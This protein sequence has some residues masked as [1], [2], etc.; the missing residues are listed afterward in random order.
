MRLKLSLQYRADGH[1]GIVLHPRCLRRRSEQMHLRSLLDRVGDSAVF[2]SLRDL[3]LGK[4][5]AQE[6]RPADDSFWTAF[7]E[8]QNER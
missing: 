7:T 8:I 2:L 5:N 1:A 3:A 4:I 6:P